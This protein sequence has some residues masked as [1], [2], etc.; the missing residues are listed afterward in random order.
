MNFKDKNFSKLLVAETLYEFC[1]LYEN[2]ISY[3]ISGVHGSVFL[4]FSAV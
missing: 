2:L 3:T 4:G 1:I